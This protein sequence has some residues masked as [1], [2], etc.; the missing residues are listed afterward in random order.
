[1]DFQL[2]IKYQL[3][4]LLGMTLFFLSDIDS[5]K[6]VILK[7]NY[8][9]IKFYL[10]VGIIMLFFVVIYYGSSLRLVSFSKIYELRVD[11]YEAK[12]SRFP[13]IGYFILWISN[14]FR[15]LFLSIGLVYK[16]KEFVLIGVLMAI[17]IYMATATKGT[18]FSPL[19]AFGLYWCLKYIGFK[20]LF[21][22]IVFFFLL[23][24]SLFK[25]TEHSESS[26]SSVFFVVSAILL[27]RSLGISALLNT[28]Y[29]DFFETT[30]LHTYYTHINV[31]NR[32]FGGYPFGEDALGKAVWGGYSGE[33]VDDAMNA[34]ANFL[35]TDGVAAMG[36]WGV[37]LVSILFY[38]LLKYLNKVSKSHNTDF[39]FI[40]CL[41]SILSLLNVSLFTTLLSCGLILII[42]CL[43]YST[44]RY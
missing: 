12:L 40:L 8:I 23:V 42:I 14:F 39:V 4:F 33:S 18:L 22:L 17:L 43:K 32:I 24:V 36:I 6:V 21:P 27:M 44:I 2:A 34:N 38:F 29:I 35:A 16:K 30:K 9:P 37:L 5:G 31:I 11:N 3:V 7:K 28:A 20:Y 10:W 15:P 1:M 19:F 26:M 41:G 25:L 13:L